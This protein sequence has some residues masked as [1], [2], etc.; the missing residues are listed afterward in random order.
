MKNSLFI[1]T[2]VLLAVLFCNEILADVNTPA[3]GTFDI[4]G[5]LSLPLSFNPAPWVS[6]S[7]SSTAY[8]WPFASDD[9]YEGSV[10]GYNLARAQFSN[11]SIIISDYGEKTGDLGIRIFNSAGSTITFDAT[12]LTLGLTSGNLDV[13]LPEFTF[14]TGDNMFFWVSTAGATYYSTLLLGPGYPELSAEAAMDDVDLYLA[15]VPEPATILI[16]TLGSIYLRK[17]H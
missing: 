3:T 13:Y 6:P 11:G 1:F 5:G 8:L 4:D 17:R 2:V 16:L 12:V 15:V 7:I 9:L 10:S 14:D